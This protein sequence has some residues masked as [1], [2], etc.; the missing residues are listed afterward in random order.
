[1]MQ[2][3][4]GGWSRTYYT[5]INGTGTP[6]DTPVDQIQPISQELSSTE[7]VWAFIDSEEGA[8]TAI[9]TV[10]KGQDFEGNLYYFTID[11]LGNDSRNEQPS[12]YYTK[13]VKI[14][15]GNVTDPII[16]EDAS[17]PKQSF[18]ISFDISNPNIEV[19]YRWVSHP[20]NWQSVT[21]NFRVYASNHD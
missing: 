19:K 13:P 20:N 10:P 4:N 2:Q 11:S 16:T 18:N 17:L 5:F 1:D 9:I 6:T 21:Q 12:R 7:G 8:D 14:Y 15:N 3:S